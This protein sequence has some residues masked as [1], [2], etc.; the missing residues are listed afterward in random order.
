MRCPGEIAD[1]RYGTGLYK[2]RLELV[3]MAEIRIGAADIWY[4]GL[5]AEEAHV[6]L[7]WLSEQEDISAFQIS[8]GSLYNLSKSTKDLRK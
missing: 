2:V 3:V 8:T 7:C 5:A 4:R 1:F 6:P